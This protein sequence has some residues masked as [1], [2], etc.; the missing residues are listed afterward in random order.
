MIQRFIDNA[1]Q[2]KRLKERCIDLGEQVIIHSA[3]LLLFPNSEYEE[4][5]KNEIITFITDGSRSKPK[6]G[7]FSYSWFFEGPK[8][9]D[10]EILQPYLEDAQ[11]LEKNL[12]AIKVSVVD[13]ET[14]LNLLEETLN[15]EFRKNK[16]ILSRWEVKEILTNC[17]K[18]IDKKN[19]TKIH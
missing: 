4:H 19:D 2:K 7:K 10:A 12:E 15:K 13:F 18:D 1:R 17:L 8:P 14:F 11:D 9:Y 3:K 16:K 6:E 5:W